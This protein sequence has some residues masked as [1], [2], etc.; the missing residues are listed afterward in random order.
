[1][2]AE[3][4]L[5]EIYCVKLIR[6]AMSIVEINI[7]GL[8]PAKYASTSAATKNGR[9]DY[10]DYELYNYHFDNC[11]QNILALKST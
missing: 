5:A 1:M 10:D 3:H 6:T 9:N 11:R 4:S 2:Q 7:L 8:H